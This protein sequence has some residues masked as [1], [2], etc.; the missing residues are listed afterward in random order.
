MSQCQNLERTFKL[1]SDC[2]V[3]ANK[4]WVS[5]GKKDILALGKAICLA[6]KL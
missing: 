6:L 5:L 4:K 3:S 1:F 2:V